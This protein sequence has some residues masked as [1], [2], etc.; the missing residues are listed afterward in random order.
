MHP[1]WHTL[2]VPTISACQVPYVSQR[3]TRFLGCRSKWVSLRWAARFAPS[4]Y[5]DDRSSS[6]LA[7]LRFVL[8]CACHVWNAG[9]DLHLAVLVPTADSWPEGRASIGAISLAIDVANSQARPPGWG[10]ITWSWKEVDCDRSK[11]LAALS[12]ILEEGPVDAVIGPECSVACESTA[13]L[14]SAR[15]IPQVSYRCSS[16]VALSDKTTYPTVRRTH[17]FAFM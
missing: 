15:D 7:A 9:A 4:E 5:V 8:P 13:I 10:K 12:Q 17:E 6:Q 16:S 3:S 11:A 2:R 14:T 1:L